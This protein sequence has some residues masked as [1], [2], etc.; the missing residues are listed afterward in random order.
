VAHDGADVAAAFCL[1]ARRAGWRIGEGVSVT[2]IAASA[3]PGPMPGSTRIVIF[4]KAPQ[5][6]F[7]KTRL[8][9][10]LGAQGAADLARRMLAHT[11]QSALAAGLGPV[12]LCVTPAPGEPSWD[13]VTVPAGVQW[14]DQG[15]GDLG[16]RMARAAQRA[17]DG[18]T[19]VLLI[20]TDC[21]ELDC[22]QLH[23]AAAALQ[24][25]GVDAVLT[26]AFDGGYVLLGL[27]RF[28]A[29]LFA[30]IAW[31][32]ASVAAATHQRL[33]QLGWRVQSQAMLHDIDEPA[34]LQW[35]PTCF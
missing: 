22:A 20:G 34:D 35:L 23:S 2:P 5:A 13:D 18:G 25:G 3:V 7:A 28:D 27:A 32:T 33:Q 14:S 15:S 26:P 11:L 6:G 16:A 8:S 29:S 9:A 19:P 4:A 30:G 21:P 17:L 12:E 10:A 24:E 1:L 31:S